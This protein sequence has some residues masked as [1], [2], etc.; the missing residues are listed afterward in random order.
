MVGKDLCR[1]TEQEGMHEEED[2]DAHPTQTKR[3]TLVIPEI[4]MP[5]KS[6]LSQVTQDS[7]KPVRQ[8]TWKTPVVNTQSIG[9]LPSGYM[10]FL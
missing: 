6:Q 9:G 5:H 8:L 10:S 4:K 3:D 2:T 1:I 7:R